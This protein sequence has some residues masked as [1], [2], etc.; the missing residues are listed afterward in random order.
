MDINV[1]RFLFEESQELN[2]EYKKIIER[3][4]EIIDNLRKD[5]NFLSNNYLI[6]VSQVCQLAIFSL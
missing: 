6:Q 3:K 2:K 4:S 5:N 1:D